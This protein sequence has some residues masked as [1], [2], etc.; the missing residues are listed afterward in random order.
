MKRMRTTLFVFAVFSLV[1]GVRSE[2]QVEAQIHHQWQSGFVGKFV[3]TPD[4]PVQDSWRI[5]V[6]FSQPIKKLKVW[7]AKIVDSNEEKTE[8]VLENKSWNANLSGG[9]YS[10]NFKGKK[11]RRGAVP[12][13]EVSFE[14][15]GEGSGL[16]HDHEV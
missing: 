16:L 12:S 2:D 1:A 14:R 4:T 7:Q 15:L 9:T 5:N 10:L 11:A 8:F 13:I 6:T 3:I